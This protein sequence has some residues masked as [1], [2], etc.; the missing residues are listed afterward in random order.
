MNYWILGA[1]VAFMF[2]FAAC[3]DDD[4]DPEVV[5]TTYV[6]GPV[7]N[8]AIS[9]VVT[10]TK[11]DAASTLIRIE[12]EGSPGNAGNAHPAHIHA[13]SASEG[14]PIVV[15]FTPVDDATGI[16]ET[17]VTALSD[18][19]PINY[20]GLLDYDGHVNVHLSSTAMSTLIAQGNIGSNAP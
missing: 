2:C 1:L 19:T 17:T 14:G 6:L 8:P 13:N 12:L 15:H 18:G 7:S 5:E 10:F 20:E 11:L 16:S 9:G 4:P 3:K